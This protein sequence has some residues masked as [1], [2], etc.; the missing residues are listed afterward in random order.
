MAPCGAER[1]VCDVAVVDDQDRAI[2]LSGKFEL[3]PSDY[4]KAKQRGFEADIDLKIVT[5]VSGHAAGFQTLIG[6]APV[7]GPVQ[8]ETNLWTLYG[9]IDGVRILTPGGPLA[10]WRR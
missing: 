3:L 5:N 4:R 1:R 9:E 2:P 7:A 6:K 10:V 8:E